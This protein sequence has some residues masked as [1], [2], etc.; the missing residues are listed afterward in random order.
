VP[1]PGLQSSRAAAAAGQGGHEPHAPPL[2]LVG[3]RRSEAE[4]VTALG[5]SHVAAPGDAMWLAVGHAS[6]SLAVWDLQRRP[7][8]VV[9]TIGMGCETG[10]AV[11]L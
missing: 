10:H 8:R 2:L 4:A 9:V 5:F 11:L 6:G 3:E 1:A 7:A